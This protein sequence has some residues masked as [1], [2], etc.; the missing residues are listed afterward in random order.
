MVELKGSLN[1]IGLPAIVQLIGELHHSGSLELVKDQA[2]GMLGFDDGRLVIAT[3]DQEYGLKALAA[4]VTNL[5]SGDFRF[6]E[7]EAAGERNLDLAP[8]EVQRLLARVAS[9]EQHGE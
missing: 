2:A 6:V 5:A 8:S 3:F 4:C 7:G 9:G 1:G